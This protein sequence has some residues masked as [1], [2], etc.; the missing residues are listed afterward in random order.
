M[1]FARLQRR[2][3]HIWRLN[4]LVVFGRCLRY[5]A[6]ARS[7]LMLL[8][9]RLLEVKGRI[10]RCLGGHEIVYT[11]RLLATCLVGRA[12]RRLILIQVHVVDTFGNFAARIRRID[13]LNMLHL[14]LGRSQS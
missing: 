1:T 3:L 4:N 13:R 6:L 12:R 9:L 14:L 7:H 2:V 11:P 10:L 5:A 8:G